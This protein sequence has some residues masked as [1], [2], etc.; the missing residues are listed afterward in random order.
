MSDNISPPT[1]NLLCCELKEISEWERLAVYLNLSDCIIQD[2]KE[3]YPNGGIWNHKKHCLKKWLDQTNTVHSWRTVVD[4]V[5]RVN[6]RVAENIR[7]K[8]ATILD[9]VPSQSQHEE[10][11][12]Y[13]MRLV[14]IVKMM[15]KIHLLLQSVYFQQAS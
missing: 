2:A 13:G 1:V 3:C 10:N 5:K 9:Q 15:I 6:A 4:A 14:T 8:Y 11:R 7:K 12:M